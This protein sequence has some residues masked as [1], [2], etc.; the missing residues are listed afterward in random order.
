MVE[1]NTAFAN[2]MQGAR[3][4]E[5][6]AS[7]AAKGI[8]REE[9]WMQE[10]PAGTVSVVYIEADDLGGAFSGLATSQE[11]FDVWWRAQILAIHGIDMAQP[12]P[13]PMNAQV[14]A[15]RAGT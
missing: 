8:T 12:M 10:T 3:R 2:E 15:F 13:G 9:V 11:P 14:L 6:A 7:R 5:Y 4:A 1:R